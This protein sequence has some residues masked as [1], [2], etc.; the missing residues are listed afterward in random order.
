M[1]LI[2]DISKDDEL[3]N[4]LIDKVLSIGFNKT[5]VLAFDNR[6]E[7]LR[8]V[9]ALAIMDMLDELKENPKF[10]KLLKNLVIKK[11]PAG[12][13]ANMLK[14]Y[15]GKGDTEIFLF[16]SIEEKDNI[17]SLQSKVHTAYID[18]N[19][20][21]ANVPYPLVEIVTITLSQYLNPDTIKEVAGILNKIH[22]AAVKEDMGAMIFMLLPKADVKDNE[23]NL[24]E[25][26]ARLKECITAA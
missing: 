1:R 14:K 3:A 18:E 11:G 17:G 19:G 12:N 7:G 10:E 24:V 5:L 15:I 2:G 21:P 22:I 4:T 13:M 26:Y 23:E 6:L 9:K 8:R 20:I 25:R 16:A